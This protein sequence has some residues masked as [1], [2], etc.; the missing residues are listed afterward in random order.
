MVLPDRRLRLAFF[1]T[2][3]IAKTVLDG[4][5][6]AGTDDIALV[7]SQ[8]DRPKGRGKKLEPTPV[9]ALAEQNG[10]LVEQPRKLRDGALAERLRAL[11]IDLAIV[12]AYGRILPVDV[13]EA[14][15]HDTWNVHASLLP[16][17]RGASPIQHAILEGHEETGVTLM[18]LSEGMDEGDMLLKKSLRISANDTSGRLTERLAKLG[19]TAAIEGIALAKTSGLTVEPQPHDEATYAGM[20]EKKDGQLD[21][22]NSAAA[23]DRRVR[24]FDPWPGTF[25]LNKQGQPI[26]IR[27][28][29]KVD[30]QPRSDVKPGCIVSIDPLW[31]QTGDN[32][33]AIEEIQ[34]PGK[35]AMSS[36]DF[37]R[38]A[39][40]SLKAGDDLSN[41]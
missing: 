41:C 24:A 40:R 15:H 12:V 28:V 30:T 6:E 29:S 21:F 13:F 35:R 2:P 23:I 7:I 9:K 27:R 1:G 34:P 5:I 31:V 19:A 32:I 10:L 11:E 38:G 4:L 20:L 26:K 39:G 14:P 36:S 17:L 25:V 37:I 18:R 22:T 3:E 8:P 33:I 16:H